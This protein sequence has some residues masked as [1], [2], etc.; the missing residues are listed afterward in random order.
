MPYVRDDGLRQICVQCQKTS[1]LEACPEKII[2][3]NPDCIPTLEFSR[4]GCI[5]CEECVKACYATNGVHQGFDT[6]YKQ[7]E[8]QARINPIECLAW[9]SCICNSCKDVCPCKIQFQGMFYPE[10]IS[11]NGCGLC[12][13][14]CPAN[15]IEF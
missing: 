5:F 12:I 1:C 14:I 13:S 15:A 11:C 10:I 6:S 4:S 7:I 2:T 9:N 3:L 8:I